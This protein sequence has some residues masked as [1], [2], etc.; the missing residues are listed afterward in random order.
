MTYDIIRGS[1]PGLFK[2]T[3]A[4]LRC[5]YFILNRNIHGSRDR[6]ILSVTHSL[7]YEIV[8]AGQS[9]YYQYQYQTPPL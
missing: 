1:Q 5:G 6:E 8:S 2:A 9:L 7:R 3:F 4:A